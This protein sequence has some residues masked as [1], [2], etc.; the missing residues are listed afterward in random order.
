MTENNIPLDRLPRPE[1]AGIIEAAGKRIVE[2]TSGA[3]NLLWALQQQF[4]IGPVQVES[5]TQPARQAAYEAPDPESQSYANMPEYQASAAPSPSQFYG[6]GASV[7]TY[8]QPASFID[9]A[10]DATHSVVSSDAYFDAITP[11]PEDFAPKAE[12]VWQQHTMNPDAQALAD[13]ARQNIAELGGQNNYDL[14]A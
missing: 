10:Y 7:D 4:A 3:R 13:Q 12:P 11:S 8:T 6:D 2:E 9:P 1:Q 5:T 14:A